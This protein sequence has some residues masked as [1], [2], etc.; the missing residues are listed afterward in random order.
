[1]HKVLCLIALTALYLS[2][3]AALAQTTFSG[4]CVYRADEQHMLVVGD[5]EGHALG[6]VQGKCD[7]KKPIDF[8]GDK[9]KDGFST[10]TVDAETRSAVYSG[11]LVVTTWG[12]DRVALVFRGTGV[13]KTRTSESPHVEGTFTLGDGTGKLKKA[14]GKG[15]FRC[16]STPDG[17]VCDIEG[18]YWA[19]R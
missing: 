18:E 6:V 15:T 7:W 17:T 16:S 19:A 2:P 1:M 13:G 10:Q 8:G 12:G 11:V 5:R 9:V 3:A 4:T 14:T